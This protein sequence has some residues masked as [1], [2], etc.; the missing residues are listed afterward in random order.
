MAKRKTQQQFIEEYRA[1]HGD[2]YDYSQ[3][4]YLGCHTKITLI[5]PNHGTFE[6][7]PNHHISGGGCRKCFEERWRKTTDER[8]AQIR[9]P[10]YQFVEESRA[11]H[12]DFYDYSQ[13]RYLNTRTKVTLICPDH[14]N[15]EIT[16]GHHLMGVGCGKCFEERRGHSQDAI[17]VKFRKVHGDRYSYDKVVYSRID[18]Q[19]TI[20]CSTHGD[21]Q[22]TPAV[23]LRGCGCAQ[24]ALEQQGL[25]TKDF[26]VKAKSKYGNKYDYSKACYI[27]A[28]TKIVILCPEHGNF[29]QT[30]TAHLR[31]RECPI[32]PR[33]NREPVRVNNVIYRS[34]SDAFRRLNVSVTISTVHNRIR[35]GMTPEQALLTPGKLGHCNGI[36]YLVTNVANG[37]QYVGLTT[38]SLDERWCGHLRQALNNHEKPSLLHKAIAEFGKE[39]FTIEVIDCASSA[40]DLRAKEREWIKSMNTQ[41]PNGYN[42]TLGGEGVYSSGKPTKLPEDSTLY[43]TIKA[44]ADALAKREGISHLT[45]RARISVG[46]INVNKPHSMINTPIHRY[47]R[48]LFYRASGLKKVNCNDFA[49]CERWEV[50]A[51]FYEDMGQ[52][53]T[54]GLVLKRLDPK[55]PYSKDNCNWVTRSELS[56]SIKDT[57]KRTAYQETEKEACSPQIFPIQLSLNLKLD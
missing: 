21:F 15:F 13:V 3:V 8:A 2:F 45:A 9:K 37:K 10:Q 24:C 28:R 53:Y 26:I 17:L 42:V 56:K 4:R 16:P 27:N 5:C 1:K 46:K 55:L 23:H 14:G 48:G 57:T 47:W 51:N 34:V 30:P 32:C 52:G 54:Q 6:I 18:K 7:T 33:K 31:G 39:N 36:I 44:A 11:K 25:T 40:E 43:P 35:G 20:V 19:V 50:F 38:T 29:E 22:Q 41:R 12:G 49:V